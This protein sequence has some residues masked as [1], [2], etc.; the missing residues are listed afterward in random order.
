MPQDKAPDRTFIR[1]GAFH[2]AVSNVRN[3]VFTETKMAALNRAGA[4]GVREQGDVFAHVKPGGEP[5][6]SEGDIEAIAFYDGLEGCYNL[7]YLVRKLVHELKRSKRYNRPTAL[8]MVG[9][10]GFDRIEPEYGELAAD[11]VVFTVIEFLLGV[12]RSDIDLVGRLAD[13]RYIL[14]L[15]ETPGKGAAIMAERTRLLFNS[16]V[17]LKH[18]WHTLPIT[19][20]FGITYFPGHGEDARELI[21]RSDLACEFVQMRGGDGFAFAPEG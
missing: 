18:N 6:F 8:I 4:P 7:R 5:E 20:S 14:V 13:D 15:P 10:D 3:Q 16:S 2:R 9:I 17:E 21:A 1:D 12:T 19:L 11:K